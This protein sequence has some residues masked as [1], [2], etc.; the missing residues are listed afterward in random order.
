M[1]TDC[2]CKTKIPRPF[3]SACYYFPDKK[4]RSPNL[5]MQY[6]KTFL[7]LFI[8]F[9]FFCFARH[10][11]KFLPSVDESASKCYAHEQRCQG[12]RRGKGAKL[13]G[14]Q[15]GQSSHSGRRPNARC[16]IGIRTA[17]S[18][19]C[20]H[21]LGTRG[22]DKVWPLCTG[23]PDLKIVKLDAC[24]AGKIWPMSRSMCKKKEK[25]ESWRFSLPAPSSRSLNKGLQNTL[26]T[27]REK[28]AINS[29]QK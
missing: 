9:L 13:E 17:S 7:P 20:R 3:F 28:K 12:C 27:E 2:G 24:T 21:S 25:K 10:I 22:P 18:T 15:R 5:F 19:R 11:K 8:L 6:G 26:I 14:R 1:Q 23:R 4:N 29:T 16:H